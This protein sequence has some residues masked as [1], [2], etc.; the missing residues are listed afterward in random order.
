MT[1]GT[2]L[3]ELI[4]LHPGI[5]A[6][7]LAARADKIPS[8]IYNECGALENAGRIKADRSARPYRYYAVEDAPASTLL[9][10][11]A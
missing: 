9:E 2:Q 1:V 11:T 6:A 3:L 10:A 8:H 5:T 7:E 4:R